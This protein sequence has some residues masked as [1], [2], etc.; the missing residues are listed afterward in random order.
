MN[1]YEFFLHEI[2][3]NDI[4]PQ[5]SIWHLPCVRGSMKQK[6]KKQMMNELLYNSYLQVDLGVLRKNA[7]Q[8]LS[9]LGPGVQLI[10]V[11]KDD[12]YGLGA[13]PAAKIYS[14]YPEIRCF[15]VSQV[16][17]G[18]ALREAGIDREILVM[19]N[20]PAFQAEAA[21]A[22]DL[23]L[24]CGRLGFLKDYSEAAGK[25]GTKAKFQLKIDAGL[26]RIGIEPRELSAW[27]EEYRVCKEG[28]SLTGLY[29]HFSDAENF[30]LDDKQY[31]VFQSALSQLEAAGVEIPMRHMAATASFESFP[32]FKLDGVRCGRRLIMD[33][34]AEPDGKI[35]EAASWR[36]YITNIKERKKGDLVGYGGRLRLEKD[37]TVA[38]VCAGYGDGL[39]Q[40]LVRIGGPVLAGGK[41]CR[42]LVCCMDQCQIDVTGTGCRVGDE[43]TFFGYD[44]EGNFLSSQEV[45]AMVNGDEGCGLTT[46]LSAR[47]GRIYSE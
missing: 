23:T 38:T 12:L 19:G 10:P 2:E 33:R 43:V 25:F 34:P 29:S 30:P 37:C 32:Q 7:E 22:A 21:I 42:L 4:I 36:S 40:D 18:L 8:I 14:E 13:V 1:T 15:A 5:R 27:I 6:E 41:R 44:R 39:N 35:R 11:L 31:G 16:Q 20:S 9:E 17:E 24:T 3:K 28:L 26:H 47:V 45:A 46:A